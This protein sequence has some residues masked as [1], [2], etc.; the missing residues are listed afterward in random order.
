ML[1]LFRDVE[2]IIS[3]LKVVSNSGSDLNHVTLTSEH[4]LSLS[5]LAHLVAMPF[6]GLVFASTTRSYWMFVNPSMRI[7]CRVR[8][9]GIERRPCKRAIPVLDMDIEREL[10]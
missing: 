2:H 1:V 3:T 7:R 9:A 4:A 8:F 5:S 6:S 10:R